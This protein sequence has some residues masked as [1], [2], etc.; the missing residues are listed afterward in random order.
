MKPRHPADSKNRDVLKNG[1]EVIYAFGE[2]KDCDAKRVVFLAG[3]TAWNSNLCSDS[4]RRHFIGEIAQIDIGDKQVALCVP[5]P[6]DGC[7]DG[8]E[9]RHLIDWETEYL[10]KAGIHAYWLNTYWHYDLAVQDCAP[11]VKRYFSDGKAANIGITVRSE[12]GASFGR[13]KYGNQSLKLVIGCPADAQGL[14]WLYIQSQLLGIP[15]YQQYEK[16]SAYDQK[17]FDAIVH[18]MLK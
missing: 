10:D 1:I 9:S 7:M 5:E 8:K 18:E 6:K 4:W 3:T 11:E 16:T 14:A 12:L 17:W 15:V 13:Y 2:L